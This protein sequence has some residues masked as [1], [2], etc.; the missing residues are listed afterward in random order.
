MMIITW[1]FFQK[2]MVVHRVVHNYIVTRYVKRVPHHFII[3]IQKKGFSAH[4]VEIEIDQHRIAFFKKAE[5]FLRAAPGAAQIIDKNIMSKLLHRLGN[6]P[7]KIPLCLNIALKKHDL[8]HYIPSPQ[9][10][11]SSRLY[12]ISVSLPY[13]DILKE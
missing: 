9:I 1:D 13:P 8:F 3:F 7:R 10:V 5:K 4:A 11:S 2:M 12:F 6:L